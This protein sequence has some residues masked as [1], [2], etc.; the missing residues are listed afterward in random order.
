MIWSTKAVFD[1][2]WLVTGVAT[3]KRD[4]KNDIKITL[5]LIVRF[6]SKFP[7]NCFSV[8][9]RY[10]I[11]EVEN[12]LFPMRVPGKRSR[13]ETYRFVDLSKCALKVCHLQRSIIKLWWVQF[14]VESRGNS[15]EKH[16]K[17]GCVCFI[18]SEKRNQ[19]EVDFPKWKNT[20][21]TRLFDLPTH[22]H[23]WRRQFEKQEYSRFS[24]KSVSHIMSGRNRIKKSNRIHHTER[25]KETFPI[26]WTY[27]H[28]SA[29]R[30]GK[31]DVWSEKTG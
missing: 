5:V 17:L 8:A 20:P 19:I 30:K 23:L 27:S 1:A 25:D 31:D 3:L 26:H 24:G 4:W 18:R 12:C 6:A 2:I 13:R 28:F 7:F 16:G 21:H 11:M 10:A 22:A 9:N 29:G 14:P 15:V